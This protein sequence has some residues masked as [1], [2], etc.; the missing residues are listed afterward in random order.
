MVLKEAV[1]SFNQTA[2]LVQE[3]ESSVEGSLAGDAFC[4]CF[5]I[6]QLIIGRLPKIDKDSKCFGREILYIFGSSLN[7]V[8][9]LRQGNMAS[10]PL[11]LHM[12]NS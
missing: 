8:G 6:R 3:A 12:K 5:H 10:V 7:Y 4:Y 1:N 11:C 9:G 2:A